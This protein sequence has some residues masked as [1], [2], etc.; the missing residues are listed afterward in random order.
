V[1]TY[2]SEIQLGA[3]YRDVISGFQGVAAYVSFNMTGC[4]RV[5]LDAPVGK[6]GGE[7][8]AYEFDST[9][10]KFVKAPTAETTNLLQRVGMAPPPVVAKRA[11]AKRVAGGPTTRATRV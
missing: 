11:P 6:D 7:I 5:A 9:R 8:K 1:E 10:L 4:E 3:T 2:Q